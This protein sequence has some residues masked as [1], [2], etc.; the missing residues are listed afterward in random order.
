MITLT[1]LSPAP[2]VK[3][4]LS[5]EVTRD[6]GIIQA[7]ASTITRSALL[8]GQ[9]VELGL[10]FC[11]RLIVQAVSRNKVT[12]GCW[13]AIYLN[14]S[15]KDPEAKLPRTLKDAL[16]GMLVARGIPLSSIDISST[17]QLGAIPRVGNDPVEIADALGFILYCDAQLKVKLAPKLPNAQMVGQFTKA[18]LASYEPGEDGPLSANRIIIKGELVQV[19]R[20]KDSSEPTITRERV[21]TGWRTTTRTSKVVG[22]EHTATE[23]VMEP[24][25][26]ISRFSATY[27]KSTDPN[28]LIFRF[29]TPLEESAMLSQTTNVVTSRDLK[30]YI[31]KRVR[32]I[33][34]C[35]AKGLSGFYSAWAGASIPKPAPETIEPPATPTPLG[36]REY[37]V[38]GVGGDSTSTSSG[39]SSSFS[40]GGAVVAIPITLLK[41]TGMFEQAELLRETEAWVFKK[42]QVTYTREQWLPLGAIIPEVGNPV[43]GYQEPSDK[44]QPVYYDPLP[45]NLAEREVV[46]WQKDDLGRW[47]ANRT[48]SQ[49]IGIR[50]AQEPRDAM[51]AVQ[52]T[53]LAANTVNRAGVAVCVATQLKVSQTSIQASEPPTA[54]PI[55]ELQEVETYTPYNETLELTDTDLLNRSLEINPSPFCGSLDQV[56]KIA[57]YTA[58]ELRGQANTTVIGLPLSGL[59]YDIPPNSV[60]ELEGKKHLVASVTASV[61]SSEAKLTLDLW[62]L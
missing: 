39:G 42:D 49:A 17:L 22:R 31:V 34:G 46:V 13:L 30:G 12:L 62:K 16:Q 20:I 27:E 6:S 25:S 53:A 57:Q 21:A 15:P 52:F 3:P 5:L 29:S 33:N 10:P 61:S 51:A 38:F 54:S 9:Q 18:E 41:P 1:P 14:A 23:V 56:R 55:E 11:Q 35:A 26:E 24:P 36:N 7:Q 8:P 32:T 50:N 43:F 19:R 60:I 2:S 58:I 48:L 59:T 4:W 40:G 45:M 47:E 28:V 37:T 44:S